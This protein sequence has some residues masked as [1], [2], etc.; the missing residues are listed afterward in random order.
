[1]GWATHVPHHALN[2]DFAPASP[3]HQAELLARTYLCS[4]VSGVEPR[5]FWYDFRNDGDDPIYFEHN[6]GVVTHD[7]RPKPAYPVYA[8]LAQAISSR[9]LE[10]PVPVA[11]GVLA[12]RFVPKVGAGSMLAVWSPKK[13]VEIQ[14]PV[15]ATPA[16]RINAIGEVEPLEPLAGSKP[17]SAIVRLKLRRG[18]PEYV[19][20]P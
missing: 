8:V 12:Y 7:F 13:D 18:V 9:K 5:T 16:V 6:L 19:S 14:L 15:R 1:M 2:Q 4:V 10:G 11:D 20:E 17:P 3:R